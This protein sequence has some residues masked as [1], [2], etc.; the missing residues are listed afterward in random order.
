MCVG[1]C[2]YVGGCGGVCV[3]VCARV[4]MCAC[5]CV[6]VSFIT[7]Y[8]QYIAGSGMCPYSIQGLN[9]YQP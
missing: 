6:D 5:V 9:F 3:S 4:C 8:I 2:G 1:G 7:H